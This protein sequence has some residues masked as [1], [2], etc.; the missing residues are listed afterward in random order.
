[1]QEK[2]LTIKNNME[3]ELKTCQKE[4]DILNVKSKLTRIPVIN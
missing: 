1:M 2:L 3:E 4:A